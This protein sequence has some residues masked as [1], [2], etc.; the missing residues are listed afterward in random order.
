MEPRYRLG[1]I[2][3]AL[4]KNELA[5]NEYEIAAQ[6]GYPAA[7]NNLARL[8][9]LEKEYS[10]AVQLLLLGLDAN[11]LLTWQSGNKDDRKYLLL[12]NLGWARLGQNRYA[13]AK[14]H[15]LEAIELDNNIAAAHCLLAQV[16]EGEE[17]TTKHCPN[18]NSA[19]P[20]QLTLTWM[21]MNGSI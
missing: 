8:Y 6:G 20:C 3:T 17:D 2:Y 4:Q 15:L 13:E 21:R 12:K 11:E 9:I 14:S 16:Y 18:G 1:Q 10:A 5:R 19:L 7:Y